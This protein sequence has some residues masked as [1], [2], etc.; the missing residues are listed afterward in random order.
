MWTMAHVSIQELKAQP[1]PLAIANVNCNLILL[2]LQIE[3]C[4]IEGRCVR[5]H[6]GDQ[7]A[8]RA[9]ECT[10]QCSAN[11]KLEIISMCNFSNSIPSCPSIDWVRSFS[12]CLRSSVKQDVKSLH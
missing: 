5:A 9:L 2:H 1:S 7:C 11:P 3:R 8:Q 6:D 4:A 10:A 12:L